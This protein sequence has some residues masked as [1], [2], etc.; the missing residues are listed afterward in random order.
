[1]CLGTTDSKS[2]RDFLFTQNF[3]LCKDFFDVK[4]PEE[5]PSSTGFLIERWE[6][7]YHGYYPPP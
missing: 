1:M 5:N 3:G 6:V 4:G 7:H 2:E